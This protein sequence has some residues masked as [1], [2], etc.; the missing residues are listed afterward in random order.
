MRYE[1]LLELLGDQVFFDLASVV[2]LAGE[3]RE[4]IRIQLYRWIRTGKLLRLRRGMY[5]FPENYRRRE[6]NHAELAN[7]LY[8]PSYISTHWTLGFQGLIPE[9][10]VTYTSVTTRTPKTFENCFGIFRYQHIKSAAFFGYSPVKIGGR[11]VLLAEPEKA[12]L[13]LWHLE[14]GAWDDGRMEEMRFQNVELVSVK[15]LR[16]YAHRFDSPRLRAAAGVWSRV[17][18]SGPEGTVEL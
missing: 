9:R 12:L 6:M 15:K 1:R 3:K 7:W 10:V 13:D 17:C 14:K 18:G 11:K 8:G 4:S 16:Q 5:A 2:Q